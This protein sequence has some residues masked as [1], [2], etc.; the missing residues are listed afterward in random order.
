MRY[1]KFYLLIVLMLGMVFSSCSEIQDEITPPES[2]SVHGFGFMQKSSNNFHGKKLVE[3]SMESCKECHA[4][5]YGGGTAKVSCSTNNCH[6][7]I[8]V[9]TANIMNPNSTQ[10][11]GSFISARAWNMAQCTQ[12]HGSNYEGG[13][14]SPTCNS[15]H[16]SPAGPEACNTCHGDFG[17]ATKIAPPRAL[18]RSIVTTNPAVGAHSEHL[19]NTKIGAAVLCNE[20]HKVPSGL[21]TTG[22]VNDG[23]S[24]AEVIF[25][26]LSNKGSVNSSYDF[27]SNKCSNT[28]CH[29]NF[30]FSK[31]NSIYQFAYTEDEMVGKNFSPDWKKVDGSQ[32]ACGT[33]HGLPPQGH[34]P[35]ELKSCATCHQGVVDNKGKI[36]DKTKH[37]NGQINVFGN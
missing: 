29:G 31:A 28:Y 2:I 37:I 11:H 23:T 34:V 32:S 36:I 13:I 16:K 6:P 33:C 8:T 1:T 5:N 21:F 26:S 20:C 27:T 4:Q 22:H 30:T 25:G 24:K 15:C 18:D 3:G 17:N 35:S 19:Y 12:C 10:F 7:G 14:V 9:H